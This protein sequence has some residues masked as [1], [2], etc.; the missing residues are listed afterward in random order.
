MVDYGLDGKVA[1]VT[2]A[3]GSGAGGT[4]FAIAAKLAQ[5]GAKVVMADIDPAGRRQSDELN[6]QGFDT[7][8]AEFDLAQEETIVAL[9]EGASERYGAL[10]I[11]LGILF[12]VNPLVSAGALAWFIGAFFIVFGVFEV[13]GAFKVRNMGAS[14]WGWMLFSGIVGALCGLTFFIAPAMLGVFL[15]VFI[16]MRGASLIFYGWNAGKAM[17]A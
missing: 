15:S 8:F 11:V 6:A 12:L 7:T 5:Q 13:V 14:M 3:A 9:I 2:G 1:I 16:L 10:D 17:V 4:G